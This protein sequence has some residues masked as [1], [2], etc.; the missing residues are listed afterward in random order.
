MHGELA[1]RQIGQA[2][3]MCA[4]RARSTDLPILELA[5]WSEASGQSL[6]AALSARLGLWMD[7]A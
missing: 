3:D 7:P 1:F 2:R 5:E 6:R 4:R